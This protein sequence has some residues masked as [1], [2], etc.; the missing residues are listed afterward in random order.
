MC[1]F[2]SPQEKL[3]RGGEEVYWTSA[4]SLLLAE[5]S[6][7]KLYSE[8]T[9][10]AIEDAAQQCGIRSFVRCVPSFEQAFSVHAMQGTPW[11]TFVCVQGVSVNIVSEFE[12]LCTGCGST[13]E[14][15]YSCLRVNRRC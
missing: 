4:K 2:G 3:S 15:L 9:L 1:F 11:R 5:S 6:A 10:R 12:Q 14:R 8:T 7:R 13:G